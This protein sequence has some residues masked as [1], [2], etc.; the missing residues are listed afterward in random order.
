M[1]AD[2]LVQ[3]VSIAE[4]AKI[5]LSDD[6]WG[7]VK[8]ELDLIVAQIGGAQI[9]KE[10]LYML[11]YFALFEGIFH[12]AT[13][14]V[15]QGDF[16][17]AIKSFEKADILIPWPTVLQGIAFCRASLSDWNEDSRRS[18]PFNEI[19][20]RIDRRKDALKDIVPESMP[21]R[22]MFIEESVRRVDG[23]TLAEIGFSSMEELRKEIE[24][25]I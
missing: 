11:C 22:E 14:C 20:A 21:D 8:R 12:Y 9:R 5:D 13:S 6:E 16:S 15:N 1:D 3:C 23:V 25:E 7:R 17:T 2:L 4:L 24:N 10:V 19:L 18:T